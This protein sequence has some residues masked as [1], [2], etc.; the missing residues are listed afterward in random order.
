M[1]GYQCQVEH[2]HYPVAVDVVYESV[3][4]EAHRDAIFIGAHIYHRPGTYAGIC[5]V[6]VIFKPVIQVQIH[7]AAVEGIVA[8]VDGW[9]GGL[10][11]QIVIK[12]IDEKRV[13]IDFADVC[14]NAFFF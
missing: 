1:H 14:P 9:R 7:R 5:R 13:S 4:T 8:C 10:Q 3:G 6:R 2:V 11:M 12:R